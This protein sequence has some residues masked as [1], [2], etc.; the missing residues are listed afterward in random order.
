MMINLTLKTDSIFGV[1]LKPPKEVDASVNK[2]VEEE[3][4]YLEGDE[5][6]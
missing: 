4:E 5:A 2:I 3:S 1:Y 6:C